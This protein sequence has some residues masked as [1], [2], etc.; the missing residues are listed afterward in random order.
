MQKNF[1]SPLKLLLTVFII[2]T[3]FQIQS[4]GQIAKGQS[5]FLG[6]I[7]ENPVP[8]DFAEYWDQ[9][10][11][12]NAG[13][14]SRVEIKENVYHWTGIDSIYNFALKHGFP[15]KFH[16]L[17]WGKQ[18]P[19]WLK[20]LD[21][22]QQVRQVKKWIALCGER[23]P[24][25]SYVDVVNEPIRTK[26]DTLNPPY[27]EA[28][29]GAGK[30]GWDWVIWSFEHARKSFPHAKLLLNEYNILSGRKPLKKFIHIINLLKERN[31]IDGIG[32]QGH[33]MERTNPSVIK[34][35]LKLL[36]ETGL[37][38]Y[39]SEYDV[40]EK[41]D[42]KQL[43]IYKEQFPLFWE[44]TAVKGIT[45]WGYLQNRIWRKDAY[46]IRENGTERPALKW[47]EKYVKTS[48]GSKMNAE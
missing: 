44:S 9:V 31:L 47:L 18:Q 41:S 45:L 34:A 4:F 23:Y 3:L 26:R 19:A 20:D 33:F 11:P 7:I 30:T 37:P 5:K 1:K 43:K 2:C 32:C 21:P 29:G 14:W 15:F 12:E 16:N 48:S 24:K 36:A 10:T 38:I 42:K 46:L 35:N 28:I 25:T 8:A 17:V 6:N 39:I 40:N 27:Y 22:A 13:K